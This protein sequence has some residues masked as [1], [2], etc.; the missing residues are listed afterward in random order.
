[1]AKCI[2]IK[3]GGG[4]ISSEDVTVTQADIPVGLSAITSDSNDEVVEGTFTLQSELDT[5]DD[6]ISRISAA[7]EG[8]ASGGSGGSGLDE[9]YC[10]S[11]YNGSNLVRTVYCPDGNASH[12]IYEH[13]GKLTN[14]ACGNNVTSMY[15]TYR[16]CSNLT[17]SPVCGNNVTNMSCT[18]YNCYNLT[19]S[20]V[21]GNNVTNMAYTYSN[22]YNLT[23]DFTC[24]NNVTN[25]S[26]CFGNTN[27][28]RGNHYFNYCKNITCARNIYYN[29]NTSYRLNVYVNSNCFNRFN[30]TNTYSIVGSAI[31]WSNTNKTCYYN[32]TYNI[33]LYKV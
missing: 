22:C 19:G 23:G 11:A 2:L 12:G 29:R 13:T 32:T 10:I 21:C 7:L 18:Y 20:P 31:T 8:K 30:L 27:N 33:Y 17:G 4:G 1:M 9:S 14:L 28:I 3:G 15:S 24:G 16:Y 26:Y 6:L 25:V 5:Q